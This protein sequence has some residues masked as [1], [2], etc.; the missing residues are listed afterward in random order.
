MK[1]VINR[2]TWG[3]GTGRGSLL[4]IEGQKCCLGFL[5]RACGI[6]EDELLNLEMPHEVSADPKKNKKVWDYM[7]IV[8]GPDRDQTDVAGTLA[9]VNDASS[10]TDKQRE[11]K[12][13][14]LFKSL[15]VE[16]TFKN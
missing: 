16:I 15:G 12:I 8:H 7:F 1:L 2:K 5:G 9:N 6:P 10:I 3:R 4:N 11:H 14:R 13:K